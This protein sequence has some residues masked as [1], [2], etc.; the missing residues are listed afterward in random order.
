[1]YE[2]EN[3]EEKTKEGRHDGRPNTEER[4]KLGLKLKLK[5]VVRKIGSFVYIVQNYMVK[6]EYH[7]YFFF[8][9]F[10]LLYSVQFLYCTSLG[11]KFILS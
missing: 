9:T 5:V 7:F 6:C 10:T 2:N 4:G 3:V 11:Q 8:K 1:M